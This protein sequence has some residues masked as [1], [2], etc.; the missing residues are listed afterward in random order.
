MRKINIKNSKKKTSIKLSWNR[1]AHSGTLLYCQKKKKNCLQRFRSVHKD[2]NS[3]TRYRSV[4]RDTRPSTW[5]IDVSYRNGVFIV[6]KS[7]LKF[8]AGNSLPYTNRSLN[9]FVLTRTCTI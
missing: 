6:R 8:N 1:I 3:S 9:I 2:A 4:H 5:G 7:I